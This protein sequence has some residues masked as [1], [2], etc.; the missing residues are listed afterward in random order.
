MCKDKKKR[1]MTSK[2]CSH[3][4]KKNSQCSEVTIKH[5]TD[6]NHEL[7]IALEELLWNVLTSETFFIEKTTDKNIFLNMY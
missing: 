3:T 1:I 5:G 6:E 2:Q 4:R 7:S